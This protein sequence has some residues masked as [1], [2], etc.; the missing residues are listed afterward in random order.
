MKTVIEVNRLLVHARHGVLEQERKVGN[1]FEVTVTVEYPSDTHSDDVDGT[2]NYA[3]LIDLVKGIMSRP[4]A[5]LETVA[6]EIHDRVM[7]RWPGVT[8]GRVKVAKLTPPVGAEV[9][10]VSVSV[11]W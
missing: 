6:A 3:E 2:L 11:V 10:E 7:E 8:S 4:A 1:D 5:L 9:N